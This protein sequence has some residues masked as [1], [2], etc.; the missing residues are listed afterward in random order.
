MSSNMQINQKLLPNFGNFGLSVSEFCRC[1]RQSGL[2]FIQ[3]LLYRCKAFRRDLNRE[4]KPVV[5]EKKTLNI[6]IC[7]KITFWKL[8]KRSCPHQEH[9]R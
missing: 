3:A 5:N 9:N 8:R 6:E 7:Q 1:K 2:F 4:T